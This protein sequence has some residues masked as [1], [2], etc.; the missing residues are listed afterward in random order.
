MDGM[1]P[2]PRQ[3]RYAQLDVLRGLALF[4][5]LFVNLLTLFRVS[6]F[7]HI[8]DLD[9]PP[10]T[11]Y[12]GRTILAM[13]SALVE[14]KAFTLFSFLFGA[15]VALQA[16]RGA[17]AMHLLRR[18]LI[19]LA[20]GLIHLILIWNG[21]ILTLYAVCGLLLIPLLRLSDRVAAVLGALMI[22]SSYVTP[23]P[24]ALPG[25]DAMR[26]QA[27]LA[28]RVYAHGGYAE[29]LAF[30]WRE[31]VQFIGPLL[32]LTFVKTLGVMLLGMAAWRSGRLNDPRKEAYITPAI[33]F[34]TIGFTGMFVGSDA[35]A[36][37]PL[38]L[39]YAA[40]L[41]LWFRPSSWLAAG[42]QMALTSYL[43]QSLIFS[44]VFYGYGLGLF[45]GQVGAFACTV[46][47]IALYLAQLAFSRW[48]L[49]RFHFGP[50]EWLWRCGTYGRLQPFVRRP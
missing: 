30:R 11:D 16:Q 8:L 42:G 10:A 50:A 33:L 13:M 14:F 49:E 21:D 22:I 3:D 12:A 27:E 31:T 4:G 45:G 19:L 6:L 41:Y 46:A 39:T 34:G 2:V 20:I 35:L 37:V 18:H 5:V 32:C 43:T 40:C 26:A 29:I 48:W 7:A 15:G 38:A 25:A 47:S 24:V 1:Q 28:N 23:L 17:S 9:T 36:Q 44:F